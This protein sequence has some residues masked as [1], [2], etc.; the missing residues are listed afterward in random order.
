MVAYDARESVAESDDVLDEEDELAEMNDA[1]DMPAPASNGRYM[2]KTLVRL[3]AFR[4]LSAISSP[5]FFSTSANMA[6]I[7]I[8][9]KR[10]D[11]MRVLR[12]DVVN[13]EGTDAYANSLWRRESTPALSLL[14]S[15]L[16]TLGGETS[17]SASPDS[18]G[19]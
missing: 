4:S 9:S 13:S 1:S 7:E 18:S 11:G 5:T 8:P 17:S 15:L 2:L 6:S 3:L 14:V 12:L 10:I 16:R 19:L